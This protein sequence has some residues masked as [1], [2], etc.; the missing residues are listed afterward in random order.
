[1]LSAHIRFALTACLI[2]SA[3]TAMAQKESVQYN[4]KLV[5]YDPESIT[6]QTNTGLKIKALI[7]KRRVH[8]NV[9]YP[10]MAPP[11]V[12]LIGE[13]SIKALKPGKFVRFSVNVIDEKRAVGEVTEI[14]VI[15]P[16]EDGVFGML[17]DNLGDPAAAGEGEEL[18]G[19]PTICVG[20]IVLVRGTNM[21]VQFPEKKSLKVRILKTATVKLRTSDL[22]FAQPGDPIFAEGFALPNNQ[23]FGTNIKVT[24]AADEKK[25]AANRPAGAPKPGERPPFNPGALKKPNDPAEPAKKETRATG[26]LLKIN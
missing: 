9:E 20:R 3:S 4:G 7:A 18:Q 17:P 15:T 21:T 12:E 22:S 26:F 1:M 8:A 10:G 13:T 2:L 6:F 23:M 19:I 25:V 16:S 24:R 11:N 5:N 14:T